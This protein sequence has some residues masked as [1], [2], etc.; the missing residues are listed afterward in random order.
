MAISG[1]SKSDASGKAGAST[2]IEAAPATE[3]VEVSVGE[4]REMGASPYRLKPDAYS[5]HSR[6]LSLLGEGHQR[7]LLDVGAADG[8][9]AERL[10]GQGFEVTCLEGNYAL[11]EKAKTKCSAVV[12][13]DL[14]SALPDLQTNFDVIVYGDILEHLKDPLRALRGLN[15]YLKP[16]GIVVISVPNVAN[17]WV[18]YHLLTGKFEYADR[19]ILDRTHLRFFTLSSFQQLLREANLKIIR[20]C[21][22]PVPLP[23]LVPERYQ[24]RIFDAIHALNAA[25]S[26][27]WKSLLA[28]QFVAVAQRSSL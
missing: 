8:F 16:E 13:A 3:I 5:S 7:R 6:I 4:S 27:L 21:S 20:L 2:M 1:K 28:Y 17:L 19:G 9:L 24:G 18:R 10:S 14:D 22:T 15:C 25:S 11:A 23:L 26:K 12:M